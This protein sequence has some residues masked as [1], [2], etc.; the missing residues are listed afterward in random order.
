MNRINLK[1]KL[2]NTFTMDVQCIANDIMNRVG[3]SLN[4]MTSSIHFTGSYEETISETIRVSKDIDVTNTKSNGDGRVDSALKE[5]PFLNELKKRLL[6]SHP[7]WNIEISPPRSCADIIINN[8]WMNLK[9]TE[10]KSADNCG[11]KQAIFRSITGIDSCGYCNW[12]EF[13]N[14][15][16]NAKSINR[17]KFER[18]RQTEYH[19][20]VKNKKSGDVI[21][22][23]IFDIHTYVSNASNDLQ[24]NWKTE[25]E[26]KDHYTPDDMYMSKVQSLIKCIQTSVRDM[27]N[28]TQKFADANIEDIFK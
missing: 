27:I 21:L 1:N 23:S 22:K 6:E 17:I 19:Y 20:L 11:N 3:S 13:L 2:M 18:D 7:S 4:E 9:M 25:F 5:G 24:I 14:K 15:L 10:G 12:N 26:H 28:R 16:E 8:I